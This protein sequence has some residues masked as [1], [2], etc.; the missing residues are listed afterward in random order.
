M[1]FYNTQPPLYWG[2]DLHARSMSVCIVPHAGESLL[3]RHM[4]AA[5]DPFRKAMAPY[6]AGL[7]V[8]VECMFP[9]SWLAALCVHEGMALVL[10][11]ALSM[12]AMHGGKATN[13]KSDSHKMAGWLRGG[14]LPQAS[15]YPAPRRAPRDR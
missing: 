14:L 11:Q 1:R 4:Q 15:V 13:E 9:W 2:M 12:Q 7:G 3:H 5:P 6:R 10:G 8:A